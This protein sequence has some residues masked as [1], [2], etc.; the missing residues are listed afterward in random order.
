MNSQTDSSPEPYRA[1]MESSHVGTVVDMHLLAFPDFFLSFLGKKFLQVY[2]NAIVRH[3]NAIKIVLI[4]KSEVI[5]FVVGSMNPSGFYSSLIKEDKFAFAWASIPAVIK[6][7]LSIPRILRAFLK[8][9]QTSCDSSASEL[10]SLA[11]SPQHHRHGY[12]ELLVAEFVKLCK[13]KSGSSI[14]L[15]TD[16][17]DNDTVNNFYTKAGFVLARSFITPEKRLMNEYLYKIS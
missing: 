2:Y 6:N 10:T 7:P 17:V 16:A 12:G 13:E 4:N 11:V 8:P 1:I 9:K 3:E 5:G 15:T 14:T